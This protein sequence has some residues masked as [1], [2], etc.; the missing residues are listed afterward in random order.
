MTTLF[1]P[2]SSLFGVIVLMD[3]IPLLANLET[4]HDRFF[5]LRCPLIGRVGLLEIAISNFRVSSGYYCCT[6]QHVGIL[7]YL[8]F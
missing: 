6:C 8:T 5:S 7:G 4:A 2:G 1:E 3:L